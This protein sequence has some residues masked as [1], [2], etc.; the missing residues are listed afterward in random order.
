MTFHGETLMRAAVPKSISELL[1]QD[2]SAENALLGSCIPDVC[3]R[4]EKVLAITGLSA[5]TIYREIAQGR[6]PRPIKI[7][8]GAR[9][10]KLSEVMEWIETRER[11]A[12]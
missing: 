7:T 8:A 1:G 3:L 11:D 5:P 2:V 12:A 4:I 9:A 10:W 6:F